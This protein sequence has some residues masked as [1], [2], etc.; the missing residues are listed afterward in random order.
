MGALL[1]IASSLL[2]MAEHSLKRKSLLVYL[3][4][5]DYYRLQMLADDLNEHLDTDVEITPEIIAS[6]VLEVF[7][8][9]AYEDSVKKIAKRLIPELLEEVVNR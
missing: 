5:N 9:Q 3:S 8:D 2:S 7:I 6:R 4:R 1:N